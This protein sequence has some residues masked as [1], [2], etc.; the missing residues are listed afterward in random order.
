LS[1]TRR[2]LVI[3]EDA[4]RRRDL[5]DLLEDEGFMCIGFADANEL[6][7]PLSD[8]GQTVVVRD[9]SLPRGWREVSE[10]HLVLRAIVGERCPIVLYGDRGS[11]EFSELEWSGR[12]ALHIPSDPGARKLVSLLKRLM[13]VAVL[14]PTS[15]PSRPDLSAATLQQNRM[16]L[17]DDSEITLEIM[18]ERLTGAGFDVRIAV[19]L[20][21]IRS[22]VAN[23]A[24]NIIVADVVRPDIPGDELCSRLK[25]TVCR[26]DVLVILCSSLP[27]K[28]L[29]Q[30]ARM[31]GADGYV[32][33]AYG[34]EEFVDR[35]LVL[36]RRLLVSAGADRQE[37]GL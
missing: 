16:L 4:K 20:G 10:D 31:A 32:S 22:L 28:Q 15:P 21:E 17:I 33:K 8:R 27:D 1:A 24:P 19:S 3:D 30:L 36:S 29:M 37:A 11:P 18:Q 12:P 9:V 23:W 6:D 35:V 5:I 13:P 25:T 34:L 7:A 26:T 14:R 2:V